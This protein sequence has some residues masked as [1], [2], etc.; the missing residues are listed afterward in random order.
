[1]EKDHRT[2]P[3]PVVTLSDGAQTPLSRFWQDQPLVLVFLRH[4]G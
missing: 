2:A 4:F 3:D 1:M